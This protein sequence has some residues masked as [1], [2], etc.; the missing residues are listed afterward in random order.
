[1]ARHREEEE[2]EESSSEDEAA[3]ELESEGEFE[4][5]GFWESLKAVLPFTEAG[6]QADYAEDRLDALHEMEG[7]LEKANRIKKMVDSNM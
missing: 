4:E 6:R 5:Q 2:D 7:E 1:M 3:Y